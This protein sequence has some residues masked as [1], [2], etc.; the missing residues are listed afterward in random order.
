VEEGENLLSMPIEQKK[1]R[2]G[3]REGVSMPIEQKKE[4]E[5]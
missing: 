2:N 4:Q 3:N 1:S 5:R